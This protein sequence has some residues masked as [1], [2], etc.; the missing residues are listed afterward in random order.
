MTVGLLSFIILP[1]SNRVTINATGLY[2]NLAKGFGFTSQDPTTVSSDGYPLS[3]PSASIIGNPSMPPN[4]YGTFTWSWSGKGSMQTFGAIVVTSGGTAINEIGANSGDT[5]GNVSLVSQTNPSVVFAFG[6][7]IQSISDNGSGVIQIN[8]KTNFVSS[9]GGELPNGKTVSISGANVNT[10]ANGIWTVANKGA[11]SFELLG[12]TF[13]NAQASPAGQA[14][15]SPGGISVT[16]LNTGVYGSGATQMSNLIWCRTADLA[17]INAGQIIDATYITQLQYLMNQTGSNNASRGWLR[18]M[19]MIGVQGSFECDFSQR[20][21]A[22]Y[23]CYKTNGFRPGYWVSGG[24][25]NGGSDAYTC[26]DPSVSVWN[27]S[28]YIDNAI[29]QGVPSATNTGG[30]PTLAVG[31]HPAKPIFAYADGVPPFILKLTAGAPTPGTDVLQYTF[32]ASWLNGGTPY[33]FNYTTVAGDSTLATLNVNLATALVADTT[34]A[35][36]KVFIG[37]PQNGTGP[38]VYLPTAQAGRLTITYSSGPAIA[39][40]WNCKTSAISASGGQTFIYNYLLDGWIYRAGTMVVSSPFEAIVDMCNRAGMHCWFTWGFTKGQFVT[41][42]TNFFGDAVT[43]LSSGLRFGNEPWNEVWNSAAFPFSILQT[44]GKTLGWSDSSFVSNFSYSSLRIVQ[45]SA[46]G[47][48]A[49]SGKGRSASDYYVLQPTQ[50]GNFGING[51]FDKSSLQGFSLNASTNTIYGTYGGL[52]GGVASSYS[53][54]P[55]R[56]VDIT[57]T[58]GYAPYWNSHWLGS[59]SFTPVTN[60]KGT[61]TQNADLLTAALNFANGSVSTA[62]ASL[63]NEFNGTTSKSG[64]STNGTD[65]AGEQTLFTQMETLCANYDGASRVA[66]GLPALGI[67]HYE[68]GPSFGQGADGNNGVNSLTFNT[69]SSGDITAL[70]GRFTTLDSPVGSFDCSPY[71]VSTTDSKTEMATMVLQMLQAWKFDVDNSGNA[72]NSGSY[73]NM[74]KTWYY[75]ALKTT[76]GSNRETKPAQYGYAAS[77][78]GVW[79]VSIYDANSYKNYDAIHEWNS[80]G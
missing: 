80:G 8:T 73:K 3:T 47:R 29:V 76:S 74:I 13:T 64:G 68:G 57:N 40:V 56:P 62:F 26:A 27:G 17:A 10:G 33:V 18:F 51:N 52:N 9:A 78:W 55:N 63:V 59:G 20:I 19:D 60:F 21:P 72:F 42:V 61:A 58:I 11:S 2:L 22:T 1:N 4:Y 38:F 12:S 7:N 75:Q 70:A 16:F 30:T 23:V 28:S 54:A 53:S 24:I 14:I 44:L 50:G 39:Q 41:D 36:A 69:V 35:A 5:S 45:Y 48:A 6:F 37:N 25:A 49:W 65:F 71:T 32:S 79:P 15:Y 46:L 31:G 66:A 43:G 34:L 67:M 77:N